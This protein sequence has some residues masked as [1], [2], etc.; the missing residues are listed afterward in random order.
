LLPA[1][2]SG[3]WVPHYS[4]FQNGRGLLI[5]YLIEN[6]SH[7]NQTKLK[8]GGNWLLDALLIVWGDVVAEKLS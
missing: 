6:I 3:L 1:L 8:I 5:I 2:R 7:K 4:G